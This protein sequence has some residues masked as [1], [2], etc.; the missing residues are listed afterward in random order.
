MHLQ[1]RQLTEC[2]GQD[3]VTL[4]PEKPVLRNVKVAGLNSKNRRQYTP[5]ALRRALGMYEGA[6]V[7]IDHPAKPD[8]PRGLSEKFGRLR[9]VRLKEDGAYADRLEYNPHH[10]MAKTVEWW[11]K[12]APA[13][14]GLSHNASGRGRDKDGVF[15]VEEIVGVRSVD[16]VGAPATTQGLFEHQLPMQ[17]ITFKELV[18]GANLGP[19]KPQILTRLMEEGVMPPDMAV[20][21]PAPGADADMAISGAFEQA[22]TALLQQ[23]MAGGCELK[24][25]LAKMKSLLKAHMDMSG[26]EPK[27]SESDSGEKDDGDMKDAKESVQPAVSGNVNVS[28]L[29]EELDRF[30]AERALEQKR[31]K[32]EGLVKAARLPDEAVTDIFMEQLT[33]APDEKAM[34]AL[35][36]D[37]R[38]LVSVRRPR[39]SAPGAA[40]NGWSALSDKELAQRLR[41]N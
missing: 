7:N 21:A 29:L 41:G 8:A 3:G 23:F 5:E 40:A 39:S 11:A 13:S 25:C 18:E 27:K 37:R 30:K 20:D 16:L 38:Q 28:A 4:D 24:D 22:G 19:P 12:H 17:K 14:L 2:C 6:E 26:K 9:G 33:H 34:K 36:E 35:V 15:V 32:A 31:A 10:P 1:T